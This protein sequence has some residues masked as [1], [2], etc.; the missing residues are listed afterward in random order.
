MNFIWKVRESAKK[1]CQSSSIGGRLTRT[2]TRTHVLDDHRIL[3]VWQHGQT[4]NEFGSW[5]WNRQI[6]KMEI[7]I[8]WTVTHHRRPNENRS[9]CIGKTLGSSH[10]Q[11]IT[12]TWFKSHKTSLGIAALDFW[13]GNANL[14]ILFTKFEFQTYLCPHCRLADGNESANLK[15]SNFEF[16]KH[17]G[18]IIELER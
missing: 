7:T 10:L 1:I 3:I 11:Q 12:Q 13:F 4:R 2:E 15:N 18:N 9:I 6:Y 5:M 16:F 14:E 8:M 17:V